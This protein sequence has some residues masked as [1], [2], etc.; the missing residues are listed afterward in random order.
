MKATINNTKANDQ[1]IDLKHIQV[2]SNTRKSI[3]EKEIAELAESIK[4]NGLLQPIGVLKTN[5]DQYRVIFGERRYRAHLLNNAKSINCKVFENLTEQQIIEIQIVENLQRAD[6]HAMEEAKAFNLMILNQNLTFKEVGLRVGKSAS[7]VAQ[8][9]KL[10]DL[11]D[12]FQTAFSANRLKISLALE[13]AVLSPESQQDLWET[14]C[15]NVDEDEEIEIYERDLNAYKLNLKNASFDIK[16]KNLIPSAGACSGC[17]F[18]SACQKLLF[19]DEAKTANCTNA[20]CFH[21]KTKIS[22]DRT[23]KE[24]LSEPGVELV[25]TSYGSLNEIAEELKEK[26]YTIFERNDIEILDEPEEPKL[27]DYKERLEEESYE[28]EEEMMED[29]NNDMKSYKEELAHYKTFSETGRIKKGFVVCGNSKGEY[30]DFIVSER[31]PNHS[32]TKQSAKDLQEKIKSET[33]TVEDYQAEIERLNTGEK[34]KKELDEEKTTPLFYKAF[35]EDT[36]FKARPDAFEK[37]ELCTMILLMKEFGGFWRDEDLIKGMFDEELNELDQ[38]QSL[39][40][41]D[42][43]ELNKMYLRLCRCVMLVK[44]KPHDGARPSKHFKAQALLQLGNTYVPTQI[45]NIWATQMEERKKREDKLSVK[46]KSLEAKMLDV[47]VKK[48]VA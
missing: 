5:K 45:A 41:K 43:E 47:D 25:S 44:L 34:R 32:R 40:G 33:V 10:N 2:V 35:E 42:M 28:N 37:E 8:R 29:F 11:I 17:Q 4:S 6:I 27:K 38:F 19:P 24:A 15:E 48:E 26:G 3:N 13:I 12:V 20:P 16:D 36:F 22:F 46:V 23:I 1:I 9:L 21:A 30:I 39:L 7:F 31:L 14:E 18:N